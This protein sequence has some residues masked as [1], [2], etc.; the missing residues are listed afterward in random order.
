MATTIFACGTAAVNPLAPVNP[1][2]SNVA[3]VAEG[4]WR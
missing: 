4:C 3:P 1:S 2:G